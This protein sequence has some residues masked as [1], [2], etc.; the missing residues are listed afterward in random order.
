MSQFLMNKQ[1]FKT[2]KLK[3]TYYLMIISENR[4]KN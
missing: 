4:L 3:E 1:R 2:I